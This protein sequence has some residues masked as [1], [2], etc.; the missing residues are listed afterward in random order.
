[1]THGTRGDAQPFCAWGAH[2]QASGFVV[3][4]L[5]NIDHVDF[6]Q[7]FGLQAQGLR[8]N[9]AESM[10]REKS[11]KAMQN[12]DWVALTKAT[13][14]TE[15]DWFDEGVPSQ[16]RAIKEFG[17]DVIIP[18]V[19]EE[20]SARVFGHLL[21]VPVVPVYL[22][23]KWTT[24]EL[25][26]FIGESTFHRTVRSLKLAGVRGIIIGG[27]AG[28]N[29][30]AVIDEPDAKDLEAYVADNVFFASTAPHEWLFPQC[31]V[32]V[33][34]GGCGTTAAS[35]RAGTPTIVTP[36][37]AD[38]FTNACLVQR[39]KCGLGL[40]VLKKIKAKK[41]G[42]AI[43]K[44]V[45]DPDI[46]SAAAQMGERLRA[47]DGLGNAT[48]LVDRFLSEEVATGRWRKENEARLREHEKIVQK[49]RGCF[50]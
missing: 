31:A 50:R 43:A 13:Q 17:P 18:G 35:F 28:L 9:I 1:M 14:K 12:G 44:C 25:P 36:T 46:K 10:K 11:V 21:H 47:E 7:S 24:R 33:H 20:W 23:P 37:L 49:K 40:K 42:A 39:S 41:L 5:T 27:W 6:A 19:L 3:L 34:H 32:C 22:A 45:T 8:Y 15:E 30:S 48:R 16:F 38:Q 4:M 2:L 29:S 26:T